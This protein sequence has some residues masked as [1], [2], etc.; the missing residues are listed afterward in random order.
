MHFCY[1]GIHL[2]GP[3]EYIIWFFLWIINWNVRMKLRKYF[4]EKIETLYW[5]F[6]N[7]VSRLQY[8]V[9]MNIL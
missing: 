8:T 3:C 5:N 6:S 9:V 1:F 7:I 4:T 2:V